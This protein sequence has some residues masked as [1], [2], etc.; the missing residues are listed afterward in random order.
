MAQ[1]PR[2]IAGWYERR[3]ER[4]GLRPRFAAYLILAAWL[5]AVVIYGVVE[6]ETD[7][8]TFHTVWLGM[9]GGVETVTTVG[10]GDVVPQSTA[11]KIVA[12]VVMLGGL[13]FLA[14]ITALI[15][16]SFVTRAQTDAQAGAP[17]DVLDQLHEISAQLAAVKEELARERDNDQRDS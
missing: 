10:Y 5:V 12:S 6:H 11:G 4:K 2:R 14:I 13:S 9:W 8:S 15:T 16:S 1:P 7:P 17:D 3:V